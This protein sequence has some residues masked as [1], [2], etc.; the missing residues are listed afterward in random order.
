MRLPSVEVDEFER[1]TRDG[2]G[3]SLLGVI[4]FDCVRYRSTHLLKRCV[5]PLLSSRST[6]P[7]FLS[8]RVPLDSLRPTVRRFI[9]E[10]VRLCQPDKVHVCDGSVEENN[11]LLKE[12]QDKGRLQKL[13]AYDNW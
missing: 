7:R 13:P 10:Y 6:P 9:D 11:E 3:I 8:T 1:K 5:R 2:E 4:V 12:L